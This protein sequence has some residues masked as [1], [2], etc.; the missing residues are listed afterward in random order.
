MDELEAFA[1]T[2]NRDAAWF[3][4]IRAE[5]VHAY[6]ATTNFVHVRYL[7]G[8]DALGHLI[9]EHFGSPPWMKA[10]REGP[11]PWTGGIGTLTTTILDE[12]GRPV[13]G[14]FC[15]WIPLDERVDADGQMAPATNEDGVCSDA[16][17]PATSYRVVVSIQGADGKWREIGEGLGTVTADEVTSIRITARR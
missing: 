6:P 5:L 13:E 3:K 16:Y 15:D 10:E 17:L 14:A 12:D 11:L 7:G 2:V 9:L 1:G 4:S 8:S